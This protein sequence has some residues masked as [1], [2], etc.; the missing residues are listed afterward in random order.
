VNT[1]RWHLELAA[2]GYLDRLDGLVACALGHVLNLVHDLVALE[3]LSENDMAAIEPA[4]DDG[5]DE[6][7]GAVAMVC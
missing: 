7:L 3:D 5:G 6:K 1:F 4:G 2:L